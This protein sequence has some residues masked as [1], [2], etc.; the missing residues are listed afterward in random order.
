[1][2]AGPNGSGKSSLKSLLAPSLQGIYVNPDDLERGIRESGDLDLGAYGL[3]SEAE[4]L[5]TFLQRSDFLRTERPGL[6]LNELTLA[7]S[8]LGFGQ[9]PV[10]SYL[11]SLRLSTEDLTRVN[12]LAA[13]ARSGELS[14]D[15]RAELDDYEEVAC[16]LELLQSKA[17]IAM[18]RGST[19]Q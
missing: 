15:E 13:R 1:M 17:R 16:L 14:L 8:T 19:G 10:D 4:A 12:E 6:D 2:F 5:L 9:V 18:T 3:E 7:G 11:A